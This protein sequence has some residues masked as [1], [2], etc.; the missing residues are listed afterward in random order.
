[1][2]EI[3]NMVNIVTEK[4]KR[5]NNED[6]IYPNNFEAAQNSNLF[7]I[8]DGVGGSNKGEIAST[9][10]IESFI[11]FTS[12]HLLN[13][14]PFVI[15]NALNFTE[16]KFSEYIEAH[17]ECAGMATTLTLLYFKVDEIIIAWCGDSRIYQIR[18]G[19]IIFKTKDHSEVQALIDK[20][21]LSPEIARI[22][23]RKNR[24]YRA[25]SSIENPTKLDIEILNDF[26]KDDFL[27]LCSDGVIESFSDSEF[28]NLFFNNSFSEIFNSISSKC[29]LQSKDNYSLILIQI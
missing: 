29:K 23:R 21:E 25:I 7:M 3:S 5:L 16:I 14:T 15:K 1:M 24:I 20:G 26:K 2:I 27:M 4:G 18:N 10:A 8:C 22:D 12:N 11:E 13:I 28:E 19:K 9:L 17:P 6:S